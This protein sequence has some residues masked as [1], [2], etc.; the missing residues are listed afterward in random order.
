MVENIQ[1][2]DTPPNRALRLTF[3]YEGS[4]VRLVSSQTVDMILPP[5]HP[6]KLAKM[7]QGSG[8]RWLTPRASR[9]IGGLFKIPYG[10]TG[11]CSHK[12]RRSRF[13][14]WTSRSPRV[15]LLY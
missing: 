7:K 14:V 8:S 1:P 13:T 10:L 3:E 4:S 6:L 2:A 12:I 9:S 15:R 5:S 11:R